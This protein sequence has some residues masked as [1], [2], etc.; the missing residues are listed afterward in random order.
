MK[1]FMI[2]VDLFFIVSFLC[3]F[4]SHGAD[5][6]RAVQPQAQP[7]QYQQPPQP[8]Q[9]QQQQPVRP[10]LPPVVLPASSGISP[11]PSP[12]IAA[13]SLSTDIIN[14]ELQ[15]GRQSQNA[16]L[17]KI[18]SVP[19][20]PPTMPLVAPVG[21]IQSQAPEYLVN[22]AWGEVLDMGF[23][24][25]G[26]NWIEMEDLFGQPLKIQVRDFKNT[27]IIKETAPA[28]F[29]DIKIGDTIS[30][31]FSREGVNNVAS[32]VNIITNKEKENMERQIN[33]SKSVPIS[34][35]EEIKEL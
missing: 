17:H 18:P 6:K 30:A 32:I 10:I 19:A 15:A 33:K 16:N 23:E 21:M 1:R 22:N 9:Y 13:P 11:T 27:K 24:E 34:E 4:V 8:Q 12:H 5:D 31:V 29:T 26:T 3:P 20:S 35:E 7:T 14:I 25:D 2:V 28:S